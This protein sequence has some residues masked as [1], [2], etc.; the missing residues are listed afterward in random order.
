MK[1]KKRKLT[2]DEL[3]IQSWSRKKDLIRHGKQLQ[4][5]FDWHWARMHGCDKSLKRTRELAD[6][7]RNTQKLL[8][9]L[10]LKL[11]Q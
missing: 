11:K 8:L 4:S 3:W 9:E 6:E 10:Q 7:I 2:T 1:T 5:K